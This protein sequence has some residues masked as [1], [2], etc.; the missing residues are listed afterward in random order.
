[1]HHGRLHRSTI[2]WIRVWIRNQ[3]PETDSGDFWVESRHGRS[4]GL[5]AH[6]M[7][8]CQSIRLSHGQFQNLEI[9]PGACIGRDTNATAREVEMEIRRGEGKGKW[10]W[11]WAWYAITRTRMQCAVPLS[12]GLHC[13]TVDGR[14]SNTVSPQTLP[15]SCKITH[16][17]YALLITLTHHTRW[18]QF[19]FLIPLQS[20]A[21]AW[22]RQRSKSPQRS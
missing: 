3:P 10:Q 6:S 11:Q 1:M 12:C 19:R 4:R 14:G 20:S 17:T 16:N 7:K 5:P 9:S 2:V 22:H 21:P 15:S 18:T 8:P 13:T